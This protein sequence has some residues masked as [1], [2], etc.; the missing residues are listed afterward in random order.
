MDAPPPF[1]GGGDEDADALVDAAPD[2]PDARRCGGGHWEPISRTSAPPRRGMHAAA[3]TG[4]E[5]LVFGGNEPAT[6]TALGDGAR[7][8]PGTDSWTA[9]PPFPL[10][11]R[12]LVG[13]TWTGSEWIVWG[14]NAGALGIT[15]GDG[16]LFN[17]VTNTWRPMSTAGAPS[18]HYGV[19][20]AWTGTEALF[21]GGFIRGAQSR[22]GARYHVAGDFWTPIADRRQGASAHAAVWTGTEY[23][24]WTF[25]NTGGRYAPASNTWQ[26]VST[27]GAPAVGQNPFF[28]WTGKEVIVWGGFAQSGSGPATGG[29]YDP[30]RD[31]WT[32]MSTDGAPSRR[33]MGVALW[34]G[35]RFLVWGGAASDDGRPLGDG[36]EYDPALDRWEALPSAGAPSPRS[37]LTAVWTGREWI[38]WGGHT[39][40]DTAENDGARFVPER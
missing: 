38:L 19:H 12:R 15:W 36:A 1:E 28:A 6:N 30:V 23:V 8:D 14:G 39:G 21:W 35:C 25:L 9:L 13:S 26:D 33:G 37:H 10:S 29:R 4:S 27:A 22:E 24:I 40:S 2:V 34:T 32:P 18:A 16:A 3:W 31:V 20:F 17:P 5:M 11:P 7:Y